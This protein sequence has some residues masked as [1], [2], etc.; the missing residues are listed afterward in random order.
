MGL[1]RQQSGNFY[2]NPETRLNVIASPS[3]QFISG[4]ALNP[5]QFQDILN[6]GFLW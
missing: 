3:G 2:L 4:A 5:M 1:E 6:K